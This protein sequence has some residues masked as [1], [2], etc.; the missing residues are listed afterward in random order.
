[1]RKYSQPHVRCTQYI[2]GPTNGLNRR[3]VDTHTRNQMKDAAVCALIF[4]VIKASRFDQY[5]TLP[6]LEFLVRHVGVRAP[7]FP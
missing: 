1:M 5:D 4:F 2:V 3:S 6:T 7:I